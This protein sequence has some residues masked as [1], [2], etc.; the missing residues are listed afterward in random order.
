[1]LK[2]VIMPEL[3]WLRAMVA[4]FRARL[5]QLR[6][7]GEESG[8]RGSQIAEYAVVL[9]IAVAGIGIVAAVIKVIGSMMGRLGGG[10]TGAG[11]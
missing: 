9:G 4:I 1:M 3:D 6:Q 11:P 7:A 2:G 8:E 5:H 10:G